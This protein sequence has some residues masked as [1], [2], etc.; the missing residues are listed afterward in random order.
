MALCQLVRQV[1]GVWETLANCLEGF[2]NIHMQPPP[3][4]TSDLVRWGWGAGSWLDFSQALQA[5]SSLL[6]SS[7]MHSVRK[8]TSSQAARAPRP[9]T[10][11]SLALRTPP[12][13]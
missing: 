11:S 5:S 10:P 12:S 1:P 4:P 8:P 7:W 9:A 6:R 3:P 13:R 2:E